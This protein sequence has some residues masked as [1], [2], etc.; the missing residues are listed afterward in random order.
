MA[1]RR[2][3]SRDRLTASLHLHADS[4]YHRQA[5]ISLSLSLSLYALLRVKGRFSVRYQTRALFHSVQTRYPSK[6]CRPYDALKAI[7]IAMIT[8]TADATCTSFYSTELN[9]TL[10]PISLSLRCCFTPH[11]TPHL[12]FQNFLTRQATYARNWKY[13]FYTCCSATRERVS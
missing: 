5:D 12:R 9:K 13:S 1:D 6:S 2:L 7:V 11:R 3:S 10:L 8:A 4:F